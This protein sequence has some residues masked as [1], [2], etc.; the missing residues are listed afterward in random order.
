LA[1]RKTYRGG[2]RGWLNCLGGKCTV[3]ANAQKP[4]INKADKPR[5]NK[6]DKPRINKADKP[7]I[8]KADKPRINKADKPRINNNFVMTE[9]PMVYAKKP[10]AKVPNNFTNMSGSEGG[11]TPKSLSGEAAEEWI[12]GPSSKPVVLTPKAQAEWNATP[13]VHVK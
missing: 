3:N 11:N 5:I 1:L 12:H 9:N 8:N 7:R 10:N 2:G 13:E 6:A 4:R